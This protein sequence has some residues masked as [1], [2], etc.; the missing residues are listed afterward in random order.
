[1]I[2]NF[3]KINGRCWCRASRH[4][5]EEGGDRL[6]TRHDIVVVF[7]M[8]KAPKVPNEMIVKWAPAERES[9]LENV[10]TPPT[11]FS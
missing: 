10:S 8:V 11:S 6:A 2:D 4:I 3:L 1:M 7:S 9:D 5:R